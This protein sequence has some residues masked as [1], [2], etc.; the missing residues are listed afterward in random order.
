MILHPH[1]PAVPS[2]ARTPSP[3]ASPRSD[4]FRRSGQRQGNAGA[5]DHRPDIWSVCAVRWARRAAWELG[6]LGLQ[7]LVQDRLQQ[8]RLQQ[9]RQSPVALEQLLHLLVVELDL[10][11]THR[12]S[13]LVVGV[14]HLQPGRT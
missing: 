9:D 5:E 8:D 1:L 12:G 2:D 6:H 3:R 10:N 4:S 7:H 14:V 11:D 13:V